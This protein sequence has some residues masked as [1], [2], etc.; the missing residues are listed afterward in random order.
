M[1]R[2]TCIFAAIAGLVHAV[3]YTIVPGLVA[4]LYVDAPTEHV[5]AVSRFFGLTLLF[6][7]II[8]WLLKDSPHAEV[9]K[10]VMIAAIAMSIVGFFTSVFLV[11]NGTLRPFTWT[12]AL[13]YLVIGVGMVLAWK[14]DS[15]DTA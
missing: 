10:A 5:I 8:S 3:G 12:A 1:F 7:G 15:A 9:R 13:L 11:L 6:A 2:N 14:S 4:S